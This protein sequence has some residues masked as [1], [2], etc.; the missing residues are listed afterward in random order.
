M[1]RSHLTRIA[2]LK[3]IIDKGGDISIKLESGKT[4]RMKKECLE[5]P[6]NATDEE[7][8]EE[9]ARQIFHYFTE[10]CSLFSGFPVGDKE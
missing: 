10:A 2:E 7:L 8:T 4:F 5:A 9:E 3:N 6:A 1:N